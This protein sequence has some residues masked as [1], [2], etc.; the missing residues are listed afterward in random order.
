MG[1]MELWERIARRIGHLLKY[2]ELDIDRDSKVARLYRVARF[3]HGRRIELIDGKWP[4]PGQEEILIDGEERS[5][6]VNRCG[7]GYYNVNEK[8]EKAIME[9]YG[10]HLKK[11]IKDEKT[12]VEI[13]LKYEFPKR[14]I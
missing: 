2:Y 10:L 3:E 8:V 12:G 14:K 11:P 9:I 6:T 1:E 13:G 5:V 4:T 7:F